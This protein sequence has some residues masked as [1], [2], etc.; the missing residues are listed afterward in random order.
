MGKRKDED[1]WVVIR[2]MAARRVTKRDHEARSLGVASLYARV[3][4]RINQS[5]AE[6]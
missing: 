3:C 4:G 1:E 5:E 6:S 2:G